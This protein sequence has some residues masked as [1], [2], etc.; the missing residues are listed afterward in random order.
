MYCRACLTLEVA[1]KYFALTFTPPP[2]PALNSLASMTSIKDCFA[3]RLL[4]FWVASHPFRT[5]PTFHYHKMYIFY[6]YI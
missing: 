4:V 2:P 1:M 6:I 3:L 5:P